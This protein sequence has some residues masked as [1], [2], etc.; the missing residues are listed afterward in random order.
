[1]GLFGGTK[2][3]T[4]DSKVDMGPSTFQRPYLDQSFGDAQRLYQ[5]TKSSPYYQGDTYAGMSPEAK[6]AL[7]AMKGFATGTGLETANTLTGIGN[8]LTGY[9]A[10][11]GAMIDDYLGLANEDSVTSNMAAAA[12]YADNPYLDAQIDAN[13]RDVTRNLSESILPGIDRSA[14]AGGN[15]NSSRAGVA[16][17]IA[18][19][20]AED[21]IADISAQLRGDAWNRGLTLA[22]QDRATKMDAYGKAA[23]A[24]GE[25][26]RTG[27]D[28]LTAGANAGYGA[29]DRINA[30]NALEQSDRQG[31]LDEDFQKWQGEDA[32]AWDILN[33]Y[34]SIVAGQQWGQA[35]TTTEKKVEPTGGLLGGLIGG[36]TSLAGAAGSLGFKPFK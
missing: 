1:M 32:R 2:T 7:D 36:I 21:R 31:Y 35:G 14:S 9:S 11:S 24:Y 26:G 29:Y 17:G 4:T 25:L 27:M 10:R 6:A 8:S 19:R 28:A 5:G 20:G 13:S 30:A 34:N 3:T 23:D 12:K 15:I 18:R 16:A 22:Q 33:R